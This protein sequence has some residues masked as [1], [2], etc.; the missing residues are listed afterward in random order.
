MI[1]ITPYQHKLKALEIYMK[2]WLNE[3]QRMIQWWDIYN[4]T[5]IL[6]H[7][8]DPIPDFTEWYAKYYSHRITN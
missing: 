4:E 7:F 2:L 3:K 1:D 5:G 6:M 8:T